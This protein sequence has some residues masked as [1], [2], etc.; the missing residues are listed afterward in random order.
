MNQLVLTPFSSFLVY[1]KTDRLEVDWYVLYH[2]QNYV[3]P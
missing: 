2:S 3:N 1:G